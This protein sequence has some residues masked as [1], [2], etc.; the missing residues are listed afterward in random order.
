MTKFSALRIMKPMNLWQ[1]NRSISSACLMAMD[2]RIELMD[3]S[4]RTRSLSLRE[5]TTGF[6]S[7][8]GD[9]FTSI[10]GLL[11]RSTFCEEKFSRHMAAWSVRLTA[12][13]Y[14]FSVADCKTER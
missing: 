3:G 4:M 9:S 14:G 2:T 11:W 12:N 10:S 13:K 6:K 8:S 7:S 5:I 1:S